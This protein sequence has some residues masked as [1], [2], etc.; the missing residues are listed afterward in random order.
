MADKKYNAAIIGGGTMGADIAAVFVAGGWFVHIVDPS[1]KI[2]KNFPARLSRTLE[3]LGNQKAVDS[4]SLHR[5]MGELPWD[6]VEMVV[7]AV[8]EDLHLKQRIFGE[9]VSLSQSHIPLT[10]NSSGFPISQIGEGLATQNRML[11]LHFFM[12][13]HLVPLVEVI[14]SKFTDRAIADEVGAI[15]KRLGKRPVQVKRD[16]PGFLANRIQHAL[17]REALYLVEQDIAS[18]EDVDVAVRYGFGFR[19]IAAGPLLQKDLSGLDI[20]Y[21]AA[22]IIYPDLCNASEP[23]LYLREKVEN[24]HLGVKTGQG[25]YRWTKEKI[26]TVNLHYEKILQAAIELLKPERPE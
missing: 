20:Q 13:A 9:L 11:G 14:S 12:P 1:E 8:S 3:K 5:T 24:G 22:K 17:M 25:F 15:M 7:E 4:F 18:A 26:A 23:S 6:G 21:S 2:R 16:I 19:Y 10:S